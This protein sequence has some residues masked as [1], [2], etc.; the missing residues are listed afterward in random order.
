[1]IMTKKSVW[2]GMAILSIAMSGCTSNDDSGDGQD[3]GPAAAYSDAQIRLAELE[4]GTLQRRV[5][6][7]VVSCTGEIEMDYNGEKRNFP[8]QTYRVVEEDGA[9]RF[10][11][12][13]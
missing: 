5:L 10:C 8:L 11:G 1:M 3:V 13:G 4:T 9:W 2:I 7:S 12:E 6:S